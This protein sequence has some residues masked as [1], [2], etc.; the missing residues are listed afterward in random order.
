[1]C[2]H[3]STLAFFSWGTPH[4]FYLC[5]ASVSHNVL[6]SFLWLTLFF[7]T[8]FSIRF[9]KCFENIIYFAI[10][11]YTFLC[12]EMCWFNVTKLQIINAVWFVI[13]LNTF[14]KLSVPHKGYLL[15]MCHSNR[16]KEK[17]CIY[18]YFIVQKS[19]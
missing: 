15:F 3:D 4:Y 11:Y 10:E 18:N 13:L 6:P 14:N 17:L 1:M 7:S 19:M 12:Y 16:M 2:A 5:I 8:L 9:E